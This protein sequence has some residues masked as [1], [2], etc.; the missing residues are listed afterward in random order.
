MQRQF[1][2]TGITLGSFKL[3]V[4]TVMSQQGEI[5]FACNK[6]FITS[7]FGRK[8]N[9]YLTFIWICIY[10]AA[11]GAAQLKHLTN[12]QLA[13][14]SQGTFHFFNS[15][16]HQLSVNVRLMDVTFIW[17]CIYAPLEKVSNNSNIIICSLTIS[18]M[19]AGI[20]FSLFTIQ[21][22]YCQ[23]WR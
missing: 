19:Q 17:I 12:L 5:D 16:H 6:S 22:Q 10:A 9:L 20:P 23:I 15:V 3:D 11:E 13:T 1:L 2:R 18:A 4:A 21:I 7:F 8:F 14:H